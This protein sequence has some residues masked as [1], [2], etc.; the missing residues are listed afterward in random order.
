[1]W[2]LCT[3]IAFITWAMVSI[4]YKITSKLK[5][6]SYKTSLKSPQKLGTEIELGM[7]SVGGFGSHKYRF[8]AMK[9]GKVTYARDYSSINTSTWIPTE[10]GTYILYFKVKD[11]LGKETQKSVQYI[12]K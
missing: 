8:V 1:M 11:E 12:I 4:F 7:S 5:V 10:T 2:I 9:D 6:T 3:T